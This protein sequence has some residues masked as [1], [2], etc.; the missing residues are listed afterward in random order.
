MSL[1]E[2]WFAHTGLKVVSV[3]LAVLLWMMVSTQRASVERGLRIPL[4]LQNLP[5]N[6]EMV[7]PPQESVDVRVRGTADAL[8]RIAPGDLV[9]TID[10]SSAQ[11]GRR[12]FHLS[13]ERVKA[14]FAVEVTQVVPASVAIRFEPSATRV[15]P[16][17]PSVEGDPAAGYI[18]GKV[19]ADPSTVQIAGPESILR[20]VTEAITEPIW[21]GSARTDVRASVI[22]GVADE[23]VR[24]KNAKTAVV[25]VAILPAPEERQLSGVAVRTRNLAPGLNARVAPPMV[26]VRV[27]GTKEVLA[28]I[29]DTSI[30]PYVDLEGIGR[31]DYGLPV[32]LEPTIG[33]GVD[34]LDPT[35][36]SIHVE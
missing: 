6:L 20:R 10:L 30:I 29:R 31:G 32:R 3:A 28:K 8:S 36:V 1:R 11:P 5:D 2:H 27:R 34:Q 19:T 33:V 21:V 4:E 24:V 15:V 7:E 17:L 26:K 18:V 14:P 13:T 23:G 35:V 25:S 12:L 16:V 22:V 9:A